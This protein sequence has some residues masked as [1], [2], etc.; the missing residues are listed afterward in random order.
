MSKITE[1][2]KTEAIQALHAEFNAL[3]VEDSNDAEL[4]TEMIH[5]HLDGVIRSEKWSSAVAGWCNFVRE[6]G[7]SARWAYQQGS[8]YF[9]SEIF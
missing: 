1:A 8:V 4:V 2:K 7:D 3:T 5:N 6:F 9:C